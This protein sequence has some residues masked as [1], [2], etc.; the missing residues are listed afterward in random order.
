MLAGRVYVV[1]PES[2]AA[3]R[4]TSSN[5]DASSSVTRSYN[6]LMRMTRAEKGT[7]LIRKAEG[8][9]RGE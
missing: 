8:I 1:V 3:K 7:S 6:G 4:G 2:L 9:Y 5:H